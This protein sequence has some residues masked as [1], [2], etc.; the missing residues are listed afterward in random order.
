M[1]TSKQETRTI[2]RLM[3][4]RVAP[5]DAISAPGMPRAAFNL[6][7][8]RQRVDVIQYMKIAIPVKPELHMSAACSCVN[9]TAWREQ[10]QLTI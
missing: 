10:Y 7:V 2:E 8:V 5:I 1:H 3:H 4:L 6:I 9:E